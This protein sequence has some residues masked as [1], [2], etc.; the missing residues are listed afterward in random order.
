M[1]I[2]GMIGG[3]G[4]QEILTG[5]GGLNTGIQGVLGH[6]K[7]ETGRGTRKRG[8]RRKIRLISRKMR[9]RLAN[10]KVEQ[11][12]RFLCVFEPCSFAGAND[13]TTLEHFL[14]RTSLVRVVFQRDF[15]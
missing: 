11:E 9:G 4:M 5:M 15:L 6:Q 8:G 1:D 12:T 3:I 10:K 13:F 7:E 14:T 2:I